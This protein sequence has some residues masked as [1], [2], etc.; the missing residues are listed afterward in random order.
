MKSSDTNPAIA[1]RTIVH[2]DLDTFFVSV[3]R[4]LD[5]RIGQR[6]ILIGSTSDR[7]VV[8]SCSYEARVFGI[9]AGMPMRMAR[10]L[11][12]EAVVIR[13]SFD[14][15]TKYSQ[16]VTDIIRDQ[17]PLFEKSSIDEFY[18][19]LTG[20]DR[21]FGCFKL[22]SELRQKIIRESGLPISFGM[23]ANKTVSKVATGEAK[24]N[25]QIQVVKGTEKPFLSP[26]SVKKIPMVGDKMYQT[27][28]GLGV[29][30][31]GTVQEMPME[32]LER[33]FGQNGNQLWRKANGIDN[34]PVV[35][36]HERKSLSTERTF[37]RDTTDIVKLRG[38]LAAMAEQLAFQLRK[39]QKL[40]A[41]VMV[42]VRY[43]D[44][45]THT[46]Q[47]HISYTSAD[48]TLI[49]KVLEMFD[50]LYNRRLLIRLVGVRF[51]DLVHGGYQINLF[52]DTQEMISLYKAMDNIRNRF[53]DRAVVRAAGM[54]AA[55]V[56]RM[57]PFNGKTPSLVKG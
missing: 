44:F 15:Y 52:D 33:V 8:A 32:L 5:S 34:S 45:N 51:S 20:M 21:Y 42:K 11:C 1:D 17:V 13:G 14:N 41:C 39:G 40:T 54:D 35:S 31:V 36:F 10:Q 24:P 43:S 50:K 19:D 25:N 3:E 18:L 37:E 26:L 57:N 49:P 27:L 46:L 22:A 16:L 53:G 30:Y 48:H 2:M 38:I 6:P 12:P 4:L 56:G 47:Q 55:I 9:H 23:S 7:G 29:K 28:R